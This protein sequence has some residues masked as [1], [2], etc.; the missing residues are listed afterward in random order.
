[1]AALEWLEAELER[2]KRQ[3]LLRS[4]TAI[5]RG[6]RVDLSSNDYLGYA[7]DPVSRETLALER[8]GAGAS[9]LVSGTFPVHEEL[10]RTLA[11]WLQTE[12]ALLFS[13]GYAANVATIPALV[14]PEDAIFSDQLNHAS[15]IDGCR[16]SG[17]RTFIYPHLDL[18]A[19]RAQLK[20]TRSFRRLL[21]V[22]E[23][24]FSMDGDA[25]AL[26]ELQALCREFGAIWMLDEAHALG[27]FGPRG[28]GLACEH[29]VQPDLVVGT[30]GKALGAQGA[31]VATT[32][33]ARTW[34]W[35]RAR[36]FVFSTGV[37]PLLS[38]LVLHNVQRAQA[39]DP[40]RL[41]L[42]EACLSL[43]EQLQSSGVPLTAGQFG[44][45]FPVLLGTSERALA[46]SSRLREAGFHAPP[47]RPPTVPEGTARLRLTLSASTTPEAL[48]RL[49]R[50][51]AAACV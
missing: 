19:L 11:R 22:S 10:E 29:G 45:I 34:L 16:L 26:V 4:P 31:F 23:S 39:D 37:S 46:A 49:A 42:A 5:V 14:G 20:E 18:N 50:E 1:M 3:G 51:V 28:A 9:R 48:D 47:I 40:A 25:P 36:G 35:N 27:V 13:S 44:P 6:D 15:I 33:L 2:L 30:F 17:A 32:E 43:R 8:A 12:A 38:A 7:A 24:Y 41:R 21:V